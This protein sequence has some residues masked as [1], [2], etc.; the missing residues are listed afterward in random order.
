MSLDLEFRRHA[1]VRMR[2][3]RRFEEEALRLTKGD[4]PPISG[5][6]H[7][8]TGQ[9]AIPVGALAALRDDDR[10]VATYRGHGW[11]LESGITPFELMAEICHR[12]DGVNGGRAGSLM[13]TAPHRRFIGE[14]SIVGAGGPIACGVALAAKLTASGRVAIVSFGDGAMS[15]GALHEAFVIAARDKLPVIFCC[16]NN[17][18]AEMTPCTS[19]DLSRRADAYGMQGLTIDG[20]DVEAVRES[21]KSAAERARAGD[22]PTLIECKT[23]RLGGHYNRDIQ[24]YRPLKDQQNAAAMEPIARLRTILLEQGTSEEALRVLDVGVEEMVTDAVTRALQSPLPDPATVRDH[25]VGAEFSAQETRSGTRESMTFAEAVNKALRLEMAERPELFILGE[26]VGKPGGI[27]GLTRGLQASFGSER[28]RDTPIAESAIIGCAVGAAIEGLRPVAEIMFADFLMVALDQIVNQA[29]NVRYLSRGCASA[30]LVIRTQQGVSPGSCAQHSQCL[31]A[32]LAH[33][34]GLRVGV[35]I[36]PQDGFSM[37]RAAIADPDPCILFEARSGYL[38][39][40]EVRIGDAVEPARG[41][42]LLRDGSDVG[43]VTWGT[44]VYSALAAAERLDSEGLHIAVLNLRWLVPLDED[45]LGRI[46]RQCGR[47]LVLH[48]AN[49]TGGFGAEVAARINERY[50]DCLKAPI[51]RLGAADIRMPASPVLQYEA[52]PNPDRIITAIRGLMGQKAN[53]SNYILGVGT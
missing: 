35:P 50:V 47:L 38:R 11:A 23:V 1:Y 15:Q 40:E 44:T 32:L 7:P 14:N 29:A 37:L 39:R 17:G 31:E 26:D 49:R 8:C 21:V 18:W 16:E 10:V 6:I 45:A 22:G 28:V 41:A 42:H 12:A 36:T 24:H 13:V 20:C 30:P 25:L 51:S 33:I 4:S 46:A 43:V 9:E 52:I 48:E 2:M 34:P 27:F 3:I 53:A 5:S 19:G